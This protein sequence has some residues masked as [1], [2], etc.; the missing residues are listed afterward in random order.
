M[1]A[2]GNQ[3]L[4]SP[5]GTGKTGPRDSQIPRGDV[6]IDRSPTIHGILLQQPVPDHIDERGAFEGVFAGNDVEIATP[7]AVSTNSGTHS[8]I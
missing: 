5:A 3:E 4:S 1:G 2:S 7:K 6:I 8:S